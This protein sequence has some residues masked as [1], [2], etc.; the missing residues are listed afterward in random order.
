MTFTQ[1][2]ET[3][4]HRG[5]LVV[6]AVEGG[7]KRAHCLM[8][9]EVGPEREQTQQAIESLRSE[10]GYVKKNKLSGGWK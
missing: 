2:N 3:C 5:P 8:C 4:S 1:R 6:N 9:S 7:G 10:P